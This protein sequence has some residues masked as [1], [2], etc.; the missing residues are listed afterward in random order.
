MLKKYHNRIYII[1]YTKVIHSVKISFVLK[2]LYYSDD[3][4]RLKD[5]KR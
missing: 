2:H 3:V 5:A 1:Y 4:F